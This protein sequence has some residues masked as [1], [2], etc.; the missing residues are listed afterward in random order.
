VLKVIFVDE[1]GAQTSVVKV[2]LLSRL[3]L[4]LLALLVLVLGITPETL[5]ARIIASLP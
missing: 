1:T 4:T 3:S 2:D 5:A